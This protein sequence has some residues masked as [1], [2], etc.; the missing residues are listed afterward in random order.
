MLRHDAMV[1]KPTSRER[2]RG[3]T[4]IEL[5]VVLAILGLLV[6][7][8]V[9]QLMK[10]L[11]RAK[12]DTARVQIEKLGS[13]LDLYRLEAGH[14]PSEQDGLRALVEVPAGVDRWNGPYLKNREALND[15]WGNLYVYR[16]P[17]EHGEYDL[18]SLGVDGKVGGE[19][20]DADVANW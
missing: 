15:P 7:I 9:P 10:S 5:L 8:A 2:E 20:K 3:Y 13:I 14:Y 18:Y 19:G 6:A 12:V 4:L 17:G 16:L 11:E 1:R